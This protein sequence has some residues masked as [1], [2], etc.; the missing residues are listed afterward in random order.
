MKAI[1]AAA[2]LAAAACGPPA[3]VPLSGRGGPEL[4]VKPV[5]LGHDGLRGL[6]HGA[7]I[8]QAAID[9]LLPGA[10]LRRIDKPEGASVEWMVDS[11]IW[12]VELQPPAQRQVTVTTPRIATAL[13]VR[14]GD[15]LGSLLDRHSVECTPQSQTMLD[16][17][18]TGTR[19][20]IRTEGSAL[21]VEE[22]VANRVDL[23]RYRDHAIRYIQWISR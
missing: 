4:D 23:R 13:G 22:M 7:P 2:F 21:T 16:C 8:T 10:Q 12:I 5:E 3:R 15:R 6:E 17:N 11:A 1:A 19:F 20:A 14:V 9:K 18:V